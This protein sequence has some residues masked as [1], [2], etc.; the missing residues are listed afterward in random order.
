MNKGLVIIGAFGAAAVIAVFAVPKAVESSAPEAE[1]MYAGKRSYSDTVSGFG[2]LC[3]GDQSQI[4]SALPLVIDEMR[5]G[6][7]DIVSAGDTIAT[8][9]RDS[10]AALIE[11][12]GQVKALGVSAADLSTAVALLPEEIA[13]D[14]SGRV[15]SVAGNG[16]AVQSGSSI[17]ELAEDESLGVLAAV[18]END[19]AKV[20]IGQN[21]RFTL[22]AYPD[23]I[24]YGTV[25][26]I[27]GAAR[28]QYNGAVL[29]TVVDVTVTPDKPDA[30][31]KPGLSADI[32][33]ELSEPREICVVPYSAIGQ[34]E[35]GEFVYVYE[36]GKAVRRDIF[37]GVEFADVTEVKK[38]LSEYDSIIKNP[39]SVADKSYIRVNAKIRTEN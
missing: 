10:S 25:T 38:G 15:V 33:I 23:E 22:T 14:R 18:S 36:D 7:G 12:L 28:D 6:E 16:R 37:T 11:S 5:V 4:T 3:F 31:F 20:G 2:E 17:A 8:I 35:A 24:F 9:D 19:I 32:V 30:R 27:A 1:L 21:A 26:N 39:Q 13:S 34:D 29:E